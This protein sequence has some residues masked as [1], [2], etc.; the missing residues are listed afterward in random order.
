MKEGAKSA[1]LMEL[2]KDQLETGLRG[3]PVGYC[4]TS[5]VEAQKGLFYVG[6]PVEE[7][8]NSDPEQVI[9]LLLHKTW[10]TAEQSAEFS[11][12]LKANQGVPREVLDTLKALPRTGH[13][14]KWFIHAIN[15]LGMV[16]ACGDYRRECIDLIAKIPV[17]TAAIFRVRSGWGE[18][19]APRTDLGY[20]E[21]FVYMLGVPGLDADK[22][23]KL[24]KLMRVFDVVHFDHG[25]GNLSTFVGKAVASGK[26]DMYESMSAAMAGLA[27]PLHGKANQE[28][29][30]FVQECVAKV[31]EN[32]NADAV[33]GLIQQKLASKEVVYGFG[34]AVL[35]VED[36]R[37][38]VLR[39][40]GE[41]L[42]PTDINFR[43]VKLLAEVVPPI[44]AA[45]PKIS[46]PHPNVDSA[47]GSL[48]MA[49]GLT[50]PD[51]YTVLFGLSR[52]V[53][54]A[55]QIV[56][57]RCEARQGK[58][59]PIVRPKYFFSP[60]GTSQGEAEIAGT[61]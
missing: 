18:P 8:A 33:R 22:T 51:Y 6:R 45:N 13:P 39:A 42:C 1:V 55:A 26:A 47:S 58:G 52:V 9:H 32:V 3:V 15:A 21:N 25:G 57:E 16:G 20:M 2:T 14:M 46:D 7:I 44:L 30:E 17:I 27:G 28:C 11:K 34:H 49:C 59:T 40:T 10:P 31:G 61:G 19:I 41:E 23:R 54:I 43:M 36:P 60:L 35:R 50:D 48:L 5:S 4:T 24:T 38:K 29:L 12:L 56:Y 37:A 53:G